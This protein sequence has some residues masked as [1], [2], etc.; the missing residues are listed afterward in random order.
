MN[1]PRLTARRLLVQGIVQGVGFRPF[2]YREAVRLGLTGWVRNGPSGV[3]ILASGPDTA[4][5]VFLTALRDLAPSAARIDAILCESAAPPDTTGFRIET[6]DR[7]GIATTSILPDLATCPDCQSELRDPSNRRHRYPFINCTHCGP[8]YSILHRLPYDRPHT[9]MRTFTLCPDCRREYEDPSDRRFH[10]QPN[11]CPACGPHL[12]LWDRQG[13][14]LATRDDALLEAAAAL[15]QGAIV[16]VK[17]IGG[18][19]LMA[20]ATN[21]VA[22]MTLRERKH[23]AEKPFAVMMANP[24]MIRRYAHLSKPEQAAL[25]SSSAP[26]VLLTKKAR[27]KTPHLARLIA[28]EQSTLG[29]LLPYAPVHH[30]LMDELNTPLIATSGNLSDEPI[31]TDEHEAL[32]RLGGIADFFLVHNRPIAHPVDDS[33]LRFAGGQP[34]FLRLARG[35]TP[36]TLPRPPHTGTGP[37]LAVGPHMKSTFT[38]ATPEHLV[39]SPHIG[40]LETVPAWTSFE[41]NL[42]TLEGL[43]A[44]APTRLACDRHPDY[45]ATRYALRRDPEA[46]AVQHHHA[47]IAAVMAEHGLSGPVIGLAL[48][49]TGY[50]DD[51]TIWGGEVLRVERADCQRLA[52]LRTFPL[53]GGD[54]AAREPRR[55]AL[56]LLHDIDRP[57]ALPP[58]AFT[59]REVTV[60]RQAMERGINTARTS[61]AGRLFDAVASL[62]GLA[63]LSTFEGQAAMR[64]QSSAEYD[65]RPPMCY[66]F[67]RRAGRGREPAVL[68]W[69]PAI[70]ALL[71]D[72]DAGESVSRLANAFH[73]ALADALADATALAPDLPVVLAGGCFQNVLLLERAIA[74]LKARGR[75]VVRPARLPPND[76]AVSVGQAVVAG[77]R[78]HA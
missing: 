5:D 33:I 48:D 41:R 55:C 66:R 35:L 75:T 73:Q 32:E 38:L 6:S 8:R 74:A 52:H 77:W 65:H 62:L 3:E 29:V 17:G 23:R 18:F 64:L 39:V 31:C 60:L 15:R 22:T 27:S 4:L 46:I 30:L 21:E 2:V 36:L 40:D 57:G 43:Y 54:T 12:A 68:D 14:T 72:R 16:A 76:G 44:L 28:P 20:D 10:A 53:P 25:E 50:G 7:D 70:T 63:H 78:L 26:I 59:K 49:G 24:A 45:A 37:I 34:L 69:Q 56:G 47:H 71:A 19:H 67:A 51:G 1:A 13:R 42:E 61:S 9:T 58:E 11:A